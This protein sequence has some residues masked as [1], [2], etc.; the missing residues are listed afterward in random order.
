MIRVWY[1]SKTIT[2]I[3]A[4]IVHVDLSGFKNQSQQLHKPRINYDIGLNELTETVQNSK[5]EWQSYWEDKNFYDFSQV[6]KWS[7]KAIIQAIIIL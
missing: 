7:W 1:P 2:E 4:F 5:F 6:W 3:A